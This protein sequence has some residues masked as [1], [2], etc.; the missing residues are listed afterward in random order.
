[1]EPAP[2]FSDISG[3]PEGGR[4]FWRVCPD[5]VR[6]RVAVW[7]DGGNETV[8]ICSGRTE[9]IEKYGP[10]VREFLNRG[11]AVAVVDWRGQGISD[12]H[13]KRPQMGHVGQ[14]SDYQQDLAEM[15]ATATECGLP[16]PTVM[17]AHSMGG[18]IGLRALLNG[19]AVRKAIFSAPMWGIY[20][21]PHLRVLARVVS[22]TGPKLGFGNRYIPSGDEQNYPEKQPFTG[23]TLTNDNETYK[24]IQ[25]QLAR[26]PELGLGSPSCHWYSLAVKE[27]AEIR[28]LSPSPHDCICFLGTEEAIVSTKAVE[29]VM[30][31]WPNGRLVTI[32]NSQHEV[33]MEEPHVLKLVWSEIDQFLK[34]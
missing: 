4:A 27:C 21:Q 20:V 12:R 17:V 13:P 7:N 14:F 22:R 19:L 34:G 6:V 9:Y 28:A 5:G 30:G 18:A 16:A 31:R 23:N 8:L 2:L 32:E 10:V 33:F 3:L 24:W 25:G 26:H 11:Y 29:D 15:I 1:M